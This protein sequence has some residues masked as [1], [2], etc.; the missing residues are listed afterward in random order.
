M[1]VSALENTDQHTMDTD[2]A[3]GAVYGHDN[4]VPEQGFDGIRAAANRFF[5]QR[6]IPRVVSL[7]K[8][9]RR[10]SIGQPKPKRTKKS[11]KRP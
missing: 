1:L 10:I 11:A 9:T 3:G 2:T 6:R 4:E 8:K 7:N 5:R